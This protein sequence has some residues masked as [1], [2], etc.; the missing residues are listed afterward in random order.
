MEPL[1]TTGQLTARLKISLNDLDQAAADQAIRSASGIVRAL[2][3]Q[4]ITLVENDTVVLAGGKRVLTLPQRP[5][6]VDGTHTLTVVEVGEFGAPDL[7]M[8]E[9]RDYTR[10]GNELTR[11]LPWWQSTTRLMGWPWTRPLGVWAPR[12]RVTYSHGETVAPDD[13]V[14]AC[15]DAA[16]PIY[17]NPS[18]LRQVTID[19]YTETYASEVLGDALV[20]SLRRKLGVEGRRRGAWSIT[21]S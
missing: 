15:L 10:L 16:V 1:I 14:D 4:T 2:T 5:L 6:V 9:D 3:R 11:G 13:I 17:D 18:R 8:V 21:T 19:D 7:T 20:E 12:V